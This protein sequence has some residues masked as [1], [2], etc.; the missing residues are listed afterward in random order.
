MD[1]GDRYPRNAF[2]EIVEHGL[3]SAITSG[4]IYSVG[5]MDFWAPK[6]G[7]VLDVNMYEQTGTFEEIQI[8]VEYYIA[9]PESAFGPIEGYVR[10]RVS[11]QP[12]SGAQIVF[13][14]GT[15]VL[16]S[17]SS[18]AFSSD[19]LP[20]GVYTVTVSA[21]NYQTK[22]LS[23]IHIQPGSSHVLDVL[24]DL[25]AAAVT[26]FALEAYNDG[27]TPALLMAQV[28]R[29]MGAAS[30]A[31]V[32]VDLSILDRRASQPLYDD[33]TNG[34]GKAG[35]G[36]YS[37]VMAIPFH[38]PARTYSLN[39]TATDELGFKRF[40]A[41]PLNVVEKTEGLASPNQPVTQTFINAFAGQTLLIHYTFGGQVKA[42][43]LKTSMSTCSVMLTIYEPNG[44]L[45]NAYQVE[46]SIDIPIP[47]ASA[48]TWTY[49]TESNCSSTVNYQIQTK[50]SGTGILAGRVLDGLTG[51]GIMG[52]QIS[53]N[54]GGA[55]QSLDEGYYTAVVV[56]GT[57]AAVHT[58]KP[59]YL[60]HFKTGV[61]ITA[62]AT[63][64]L[65][66]QVVPEI[67]LNQP[68]PQGQIVYQ[69]LN[70][71]DDPSP[72]SQ[73]FAAAVTG[74]NLEFKALFPPYQ[75][76][77]DLYLAMSIN[78]PGLSGRLFM[79]KSDNT[80]IEFGGEL[81]PW[82]QGVTAAQTGALPIPAF[83]SGFPLAPYTLYAL[84]TPD[85]STLSSYEMSYLNTTLTQGPPKGQ[86][87]TYVS[88]PSENPDPLT[89]PLAAKVSAGN[90]LLNAHFPMQKEPVSI[91]LAYLT[92]GG[93]LYL[94]KSD[95]TPEKLSGTLW[96]WREN[97]T[98]PQAVQ[99]ASIP[100]AQM[101]PGVYYFYSLV[102]TDPVAL[103][104]YELIG[105]SMNVTQ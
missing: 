42:S 88:N 58:R 84:V 67:S 28:D 38:A 82:R 101:A 51:K 4:L 23:G 14:P 36:V 32:T 15:F 19:S 31:S 78:Y 103:S 6:I 26:G 63:T 17:G 3:E 11:A 90:L 68:V 87:V 8:L 70:P 34:D 41:I 89:Q 37:Y 49:E 73:P 45:Y 94:I 2:N 21:P 100:T 46:D 12:V 7:K 16:T 97:I 86:N 85:S 56:A 10:D 18:G 76:P 9:P 77:V 102:T 24:L 92:P 72:P 33:G 83:T 99:L 47:N 59:G 30:I 64:P 54:T 13:M 40:G 105:F 80:I 27:I 44:T 74:K 55:T 29:P 20:A 98:A 79:V 75:Q 62:G 60:D 1:Y 96:P 53:C 43:S 93:E 57:N 48:G 65:N 104:N 22:T 61:S 35:D 71:S 66:I 52:A 5:S 39:V 50:G 91:F 95:N 25:K 81:H 69:V